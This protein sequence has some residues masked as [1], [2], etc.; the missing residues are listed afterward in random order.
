M[1]ADQTGTSPAIEATEITHASIVEVLRGI[2]TPL[3]TLQEICENDRCWSEAGRIKEQI[4][5]VDHLLD[6]LTRPNPDANSRFWWLF[7]IGVDGGLVADGLELN[8]RKLQGA[9][10]NF[11]L[12][13]FGPEFKFKLI[14]GPDAAA[15]K[16]AQGK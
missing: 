8:E 14:G 1:P 11:W 2:L 13:A 9:M 7:A 4:A 3:K 5:K 10:G 16:K 6:G 12:T 15:V